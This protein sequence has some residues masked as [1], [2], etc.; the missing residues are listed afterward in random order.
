MKNTIQ[1]L[2]ENDTITIEGH[3]QSNE[4]HQAFRNP[5]PNYQKGESSRKSVNHIEDLIINHIYTDDKRI[6]VIKFKEKME[7]RE[8]NATT[9]AQAKVVLKGASSKYTGRTP[10]HEYDLVNQL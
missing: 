2:I 6:N 5:L 8:V 7:Y 9:R 4:D 1:D 10:Q 3:Q